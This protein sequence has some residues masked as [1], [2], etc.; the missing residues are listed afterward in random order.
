MKKAVLQI[1]TIRQ[2]N[3]YVCGP[4]T[5]KL[6]FDFFGKKISLD[7]IIFVAKSTFEG[8]T[9]PKNLIKTARKFGFKT[10]QKSNAT[11]TDIEKQIEKQFPVIIVYQAWGDGHYSVIYGFNKTY[12]FISDPAFE[13]GYR[14]IKKEVLVNSWHDFD[15]HGKPFNQWMMVIKPI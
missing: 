8:G 15:M 10:L 2:P 11:I 5:L 1:G 9:S 4:A 13:K 3:N 14:K 12:F 6:V 7:E